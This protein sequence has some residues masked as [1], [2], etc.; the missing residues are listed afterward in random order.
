M[1]SI[2]WAYRLAGDDNYYTIN[3]APV[4]VDEAAVREV[5]RIEQRLADDT[6][7]NVWPVEVSA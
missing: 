3:F 1:K 7:F 5:V 6:E 2:T 4:A